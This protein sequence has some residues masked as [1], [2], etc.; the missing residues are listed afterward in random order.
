MVLS[1]NRKNQFPARKTNLSLSQKSHKIAY[2]QKWTPAKN[3][4]PHGRFNSKLDQQL[5]SYSD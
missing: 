5:Y 3:F 1:E 4:V 2:P